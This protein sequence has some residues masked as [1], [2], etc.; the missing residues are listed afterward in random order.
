M[1]PR[2][3]WALSRPCNVLS[4]SP[5]EREFVPREKTPFR[6]R[7]VAGEIRLQ[8]WAGARGK[9]ICLGR[10]RAGRVGGMACYESD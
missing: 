10:F 6:G 8:G 9:E 3:Y 4:F 2:L 7:G 1:Q 5:G